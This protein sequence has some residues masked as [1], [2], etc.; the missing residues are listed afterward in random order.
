MLKS[1]KRELGF[2]KAHIDFVPHHLSAA[3]SATKAA[4]MDGD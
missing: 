1:G 4:Y 3:S 2:F